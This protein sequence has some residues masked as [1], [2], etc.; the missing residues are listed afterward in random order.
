MYFSFL[1]PCEFIRVSW[2]SFS[3]LGTECL[4]SPGRPLGDLSLWVMIV[5]LRIFEWLP[6]V[7]LCVPTIDND[8]NSWCNFLVF[9]GLHFQCKYIMLLLISLPAF[10]FPTVLVC[11][12]HT[13]V[14]AAK[15][16]PLSIVTALVDKIG[17]QFCYLFCTFGDLVQHQPHLCY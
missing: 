5:M 7:K 10:C 15:M 4:W 6:Y 14:E 2:G 13:K 1:M 8:W 12:M 3:D 9:Q 17:K 16:S 11:Y